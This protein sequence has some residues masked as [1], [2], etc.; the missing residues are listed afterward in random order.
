MKKN[1]AV[2]LAVLLAAAAL[3]GRA[4]RM[5]FRVSG[6]IIREFGRGRHIYR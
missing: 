3:S 2:V 5:I 4:E 6:E 1:F